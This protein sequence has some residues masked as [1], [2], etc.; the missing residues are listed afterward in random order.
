MF[1]FLWL[2]FIF[3]Y[4]FEYFE[5]DDPETTSEEFSTEGDLLERMYADSLRGDKVPAQYVQAVKDFAI[6]KENEKKE[7][8]QQNA[9]SINKYVK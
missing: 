1:S 4:K 6:Q 9:P 3:R 8:E 7:Q 2:Y 5:D